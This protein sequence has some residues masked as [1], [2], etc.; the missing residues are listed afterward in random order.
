VYSCLPQ[1]NHVGIIFLDPFDAFHEK[2]DDKE[3]DIGNKT[4]WMQEANFVFFGV[5]HS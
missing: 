4:Q 5:N 2:Y 1:T 3:N